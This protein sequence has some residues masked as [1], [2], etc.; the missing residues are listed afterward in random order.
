MS[1]KAKRASLL[2]LVRRVVLWSTLWYPVAAMAA[3]PPDSPSPSNYGGAG[4]LD[5]RTARFLPD[6]YLDI[7]TSFTQPDDRY[8]LTYQALPWAEFT[9]RYSIT[10][11]IFDTGVPLHDR[12]FDAKFRLSHETEYVPE[13][14]L[15][16]Q[17]FLGTGIYSAEY[18][19]GSKRWG[20]F[21]F[22]LGIG[23]GRLASRGTFENPFGLFSK[24][25]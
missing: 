23:W 14:A 8:A 4:L 6:G 7:S 16:L 20:P 21:D 11:A 18:L 10:R 5:M 9:F 24:S 2:A 3:E 25:F 19:A 12:S 1:F 13:I 15:G 22:T 17:D